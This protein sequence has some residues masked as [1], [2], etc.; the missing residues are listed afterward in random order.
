MSV[1]SLSEETFQRAGTAT[2]VAKACEAIAPNWPLDKMIAVNPFWQLK[3]H[4]FDYVSSYLA[5]IS[6]V[7]AI[8]PH[9]HW[10]SLYERGHITEQALQESL[11]QS[12]LSA[13]AEEIVDTLQ[14]PPQR[15][16]RLK[17]L[18][19]L[20]DVHRDNTQMQWA[21]ETLFQVSQFCAAY[22]QTDS[23]IERING[24]SPGNSFY[25]SWRN[26]IAKDAGVGIVMGIP[27]LKPD[28]EA[29]P[30]DIATLFE[31]AID[32]LSIEQKS[33]QSYMHA[34]L[35]SIN[36]WAAY[37]SYR[38]WH[39]KQ[40]EMHGLLAVMLAWEWIIHRHSQRHNKAVFEQ[41]SVRF[42]FEQVNINRK[43][44]QHKDYEAVLWVAMSAYE[45]TQQQKLQSRLSKIQKHKGPEADIQAFF[46][47]DVRS[48]IM[49]RALEAQSDT[50]QTA[51]Y[52]GFFGIPVNYQ[53]A[54]TGVMRPQLPGLIQA[55]V[56]AT[57]KA[58]DAQ[59]F[60]A[61]IR[62]TAWAN[63][64]NTPVGAFSM[65]E[66]AGWWHGF[67]MLKNMWRPSRADNP[68]SQLSHHETWELHREG[69]A[70]STSECADIAMNVIKSMSIS[71]FAPTVLLI[72]HCSHSTNNLHAA[73]LDCGACGGQSG[74]VNVRIL[75]MLLN[76]QTIRKALAERGI[77]IA[78]NTRFIAAIH[79]TTTDDITCFGGNLPL[80]LENWLIRA[81]SQAQFERSQQFRGGL[82]FESEKRRHKMFTLRSADWSQVQAE[83]G[84]AGNQAFI[85][86]PRSWTRGINLEGKTFLHDYVWQS[87]TN[88]SILEQLMTAPMI[89]TNWINMQYNASVT[90]NVK[91]GCGNKTL[92][93]AVADNIG[94]FEGNSGDLRV[95]LSKQSL[96]D[97]EQWMHLPQRLSV[98]IAAPNE[99]IAKVVGKHRMVR[100]LID[101]DWLYLFS[102]DSK[103]CI[104]R[105][106]H[107]KWY[108]SAG[109][110]M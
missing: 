51:G 92:H 46:C 35:L 79:N 28:V 17:R 84:L 5:A 105:Y 14:R 25:L 12:D 1:I 39:D 42:R 76:D 19:E 34:L 11:A 32:F 83:W 50:I 72:G 52:A 9:A 48:E 78:K 21:E 65:V 29:L 59:R 6:D 73:G 41:V 40:D 3:H 61:V 47:I 43:I 102:W 45:H 55:T 98:Y 8:M 23:P 57:E 53:P 70:L 36:G 90:D 88:G 87:D 38:N 77:N 64:S 85:I 101:N 24:N 71:K 2:A 103:G 81:R 56:I 93:N 89:V 27:S 33:V 16:G 69:A 4:P 74:E 94:V 66:A 26:A 100:D 54:H 91:L 109:F 44:Q 62:R 20:Y 15:P 13:S 10:L 110:S 82:Q 49:R 97:G 63:W 60:D 30:D 75:A 68:V 80:K 104:E 18:T 107:D 7:R 22:F 108:K 96:H 37:L 67:T 86:A 31:Q 106:Y 95:G 58:A 99:L